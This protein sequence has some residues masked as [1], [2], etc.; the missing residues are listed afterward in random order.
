[1]KSLSLIL[2]FIALNTTVFCQKLETTE[3]L[4]RLVFDAL[5]EKNN[6]L[7][8]SAWM[9]KTDFKFAMIKT[10]EERNQ[11]EKIL[12]DSLIDKIIIDYN[13]SIEKS[14]T[15]TITNGESDGIKWSD[16]VYSKTD[17]YPRSGETNHTV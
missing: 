15:E 12:E 16:I 13:I 11:P 4:G 7:F 5:K 9:S 6:E 14:F 2:T 17:Y 10:F 1:M 3:M 8:Q